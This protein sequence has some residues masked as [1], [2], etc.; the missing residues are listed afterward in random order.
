MIPRSSTRLTA[1]WR[2]LR[3]PSRHPGQLSYYQITL[4]RATTVKKKIY[5][6]QDSALVMLVGTDSGIPRHSSQIASTWHEMDAWVHM[7]GVDPMAMIGCDL[8][9]GGYDE[10]GQRLRLS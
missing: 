10:G 4:L 8:L 1:S 9:A 5:Q 2:T 7:L 3:P 6:L